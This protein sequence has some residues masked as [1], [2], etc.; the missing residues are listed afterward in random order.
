MTRKATIKRLTNE[1]EIELELD[2]DGDGSS[3]IQTGVIEASENEA[4]GVEP[5]DFKIVVAKSHE[6]FRRDYE[7][8]A[9]GILYCSAPGCATPFLDEVDFT[10]TTRPLFPTDDLDDPSQAEWAGAMT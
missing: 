2:L 6:G 10:R 4:A 1:T 9:A 5:R 7:P 8:F 3:S